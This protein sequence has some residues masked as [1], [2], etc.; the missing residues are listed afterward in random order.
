LDYLITPHFIQSEN[1][2]EKRKVQ[3]LGQKF[4]LFDNID[5]ILTIDGVEIISESP[6]YKNGKFFIIDEVATVK[7]NLYEYYAV[8]NPIL[9]DYIDKQDSLIVDKEKSDPIG[10]NDDGEIIYDTVANVYNEFEELYFPVK[11][12]SRYETATIVFPKSEDYNNALTEMAKNLNSEGMVDYNDIP[13]E[14]QNRILM[15]FLLNQGVFENMR[16]PQEFLETTPPT[17]EVLLKNIL[18]DTIPIRYNPIDKTIL[19]NGFAYNYESFHIPD[20]LYMNPSVFEGES[21]LRET[22]VNKY[23][24]KESVKADSDMGFTPDK[25]FFSN[26][27]ND[28]V[29]SIIFPQGYEGAFSVEFTM[30]AQFP[31]KYLLVVSTHMYYGGIYDV[32]VNDELTGTF[33][34]Y[35]FIRFNGYN[36]SVTGDR[37]Y[38]EGNI[39]KFDMWVENITEYSTVKIKFVYTG[40]GFSFDQGFIIDKIALEPVE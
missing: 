11:H 34:Y 38:P 28:S 25:L 6:L 32:Y 9:K 33:D 10:F 5:R 1:I 7:P 8:E 23:T 20:S 13:L 30:P 35:D 17:N 40:P 26:A 4:M 14:W 29:V 3:T 39:N 16:E 37:Y 31:R 27:S 12:E 21:L 18:G 15:P 24:W 2:K 22:G 36:Y 19:S